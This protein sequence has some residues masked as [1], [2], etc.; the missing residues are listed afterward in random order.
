ML[1]YFLGT[2]LL[3][4]DSPEQQ[5]SWPPKLGEELPLLPSHLLPNFDVDMGG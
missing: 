2:A 4:R 5:W 3:P 1:L